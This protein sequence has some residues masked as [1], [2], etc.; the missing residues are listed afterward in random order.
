MSISLHM[1]DETVKI[2]LVGGD[3]VTVKKI[4]K[5][6]GRADT[7][8]FFLASADDY[9][10]A[11]RKIPGMRPDII[12][13]DIAGGERGFETVRTLLVEYR[14]I[15]VVVLTRREHRLHAIDAVRTGAQDYILE[16][17]LDGPLLIRTIDFAIA[18]KQIENALGQ[19]LR[20]WHT[21]FDAMQDAVAIVDLEGRIIRSNRSLADKTRVPVTELIGRDYYDVI[22]RIEEGLPIQ[23]MRDI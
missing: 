6:L 5:L 7:E 21:T 13:A 20:E 2:L 10:E 8:S 12:L 22:G 18:R 4:R 1:V 15:P 14:T 17:K 9:D 23:A 19:S 3:S 16:D 11:C